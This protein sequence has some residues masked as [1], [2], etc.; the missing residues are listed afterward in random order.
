MAKNTPAHQL[1][2]LAQ[3]ALAL[4]AEKDYNLLLERMI[5]GCIEIAG[6]DA[7]TLYTLDSK[8]PWLLNFSVV[9]NLS[10]GMTSVD[11]PGIRY[12]NEEGESPQ[13]VVI[14]TFLQQRTIS[15]PDAYHCDTYDYSGTILFDRQFNYHSQSFLCVPLKDHQG[16]M[17]GVLQLINAKN[18]QGNIVEFTPSTISTIESISSMAATVLTKR[19]LIDAQRELFEASIK[20]LARAIDHKSP[21]TGRHCENLPTIAD[22]I[23]RSVSAA[24]E[25]PFKDVCFNDEDMYELKIAAWMHDCGKITTPEYIVEKGTK[26]E[27]IFD[28]IDLIRTRFNNYQQYLY[29]RYLKEEISGDTFAMKQ[30]A[31]DCDLDFIEKTNR[32]G[33]FMDDEAVERIHQIAAIT[34]VD[35]RGQSHHLLNDDE[36]KNLTIRKG[37]LNSEERQIMQDHIVV[38]Q[39]MLNALPYPKHLQNVPEIAGNHHECMD[40]SGYPNGLTGDQLSLRA[41]IMCIADVFE[42][43]TAPDRPY[44]KGMKLSQSLSI[45][46]RMATEGHLDPTLFQLFVAS[47]A[48]MEY[49]SQHMDA[50][51]VDSV[52]IETILQGLTPQEPAT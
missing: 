50:H 25:G 26:L 20:M 40:G 39:D 3:L 10:L 49:A 28:R 5:D 13:L 33:E 41:R 12:R 2:Q 11:L 43:L 38:T 6:C 19:R 34:W 16:E 15:I 48:Y 29:T 23:A 44:K 31:L 24:N 14:Q 36:V 1:Q 8:D 21:V 51:Q 7:G 32:G 37:T 47:G 45:M 27:T 46:A 9:R 35:F 52:D 18:E 42:A 30:K 22:I 17:I 4:T